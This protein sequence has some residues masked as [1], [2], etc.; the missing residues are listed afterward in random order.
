MIRTINLWWGF[1]REGTDQLPSFDLGD[2]VSVPGITL[3]MS[4]SQMGITTNGERSWLERSLAIRDRLGPFRLAYLEALVRAADVRASSEEQRTHWGGTMNHSIQLLTL[5]GC[6]PEPLMSYLKAMGVLRLIAEQKD[7]AARGSWA[8]STT[9]TLHSLLERE[10]L[11]GFF[12]EEYQP[13][14]IVAPW[15]GGSGFYPK[16]NHRAIDSILRSDNPRLQPY[17]QAIASA[18]H[19]LS[20]L[21]VNQAPSQAKDRLLKASVLTRCRNTMPESSLHW[22]DSAYVLTTDGPR[23]PPLLGTGGN[24]GRLEFTNNFMQNLVLAIANTSSEP[25]HQK[26]RQGEGASPLAWLSAAL[27]GDES[28]ALPKGPVG[29]FN[30][31]GVGGPNATAGFEGSSLTNPWDYVLMIEGA[32]FFAGAVARRLSAESRSRAVFPLYR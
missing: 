4:I 14:P 11:L 13:T 25:A 16:D 15:N 12:M 7:P 19:I 6:S 30:P 20:D 3:D 5:A 22:L 8:T 17:Q 10:E 27:F 9:F 1:R 18:Q 24:D 2:G 23:Y 28:P 21:R 29:Q 31:G 26:R 32:L